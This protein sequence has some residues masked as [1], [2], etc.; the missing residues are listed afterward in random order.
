MKEFA[1]GVD[2]GGTSVK[3]GLFTYKG[4]LKEKW[5]IPTNVSDDGKRIIP[6]IAASI[7]KKM[8][9]RNLTE[10][11]IEGVGIGLPGPVDDSGVI[12]KAVNL[13]WNKTFNVAGQ[14]SDLL[15]GMKVKAGNDANV[16]ALGECWA[17]SGK[18]YNDLVMV[19]LGTGI[20]GGVIINGKIL[21]G[22]TG[23]A[24]EIG[25]IHV[26]DDEEVKCNCGNCGCLEQYAS[27]TGIVR[28]LERELEASNDDSVMR[29][30]KH[31][32]KDVWD[33][34][35]EG[36]ALAIRVAEK[37]GAYL[38]KALAGIAAVLNPELIV[39]GGGVSLS[40]D[41]IM[42]FIENNFKKT[43]FHASRET[44]FTRA[45]LGNDGGI[46]GAAKLVL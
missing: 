9:E 45:E 32:A 37:F 42:P 36:D 21:A 43:V 24:G 38:G 44:K 1:I 35:E 16:A 11:D 19:T 7:K 40:G 34:V 10:A 46:Y 15:D 39:I 23:A 2:V 33:A 6:D 13:H 4:E 17:G 5:S 3:M 30:K 29:T 18:G 27:A 20:G 12:R 41:V 28:L 31:T 26:N 25:H 8:A 14:L 22:D